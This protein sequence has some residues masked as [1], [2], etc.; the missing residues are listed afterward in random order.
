ML[1]PQ[2]ST[3]GCF[4]ARKRRVPDRKLLV[5]CGLELALGALLK[6]EPGP[7][8]L[9]RAGSCSGLAVMTSGKRLALPCVVKFILGMRAM[10]CSSASAAAQSYMTSGASLL[11][12][13]SGPS[14]EVLLT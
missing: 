5:A 6:Y 14:R 1:N 8:P 9:M 2:K 13:F 4:L 12:I 10:R 11:R 3:I 7:M